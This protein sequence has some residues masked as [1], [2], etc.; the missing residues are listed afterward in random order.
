[1]DKYCHPVCGLDVTHIAGERGSLRVS[2]P[3]KSIWVPILSALW[4]HNDPIDHNHPPSLR[5]IAHNPLPTLHLRTQRPIVVCNVIPIIGPRREGCTLNGAD[6]E[7]PNGLRD[8]HQSY[9]PPSS[10]LFCLGVVSGV[11][12]HTISRIVILS[13]TM[14]SNA[15]NQ[16]ARTLAC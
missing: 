7:L 2:A 1:V 16:S 11:P 5:A 14:P 9:H 13:V 3:A 6:A 12:I 10:I 15:Q 4:S 8:E